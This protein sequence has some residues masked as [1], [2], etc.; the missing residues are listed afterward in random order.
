MKFEPDISRRVECYHVRCL[1]AFRRTRL[2]T[3]KFFS[4]FGH[5]RNTTVP[6]QSTLNPTDHQTAFAPQLFISNGIKDI[7]FYE[8]AFAAREQMRF[9]NDD[10]S[11][12][13]AELSI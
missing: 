6:N 11:I 4:R 7:S 9:S 3:L 2:G 1:H 10:G 12:H 13:V 8:K 5:Q